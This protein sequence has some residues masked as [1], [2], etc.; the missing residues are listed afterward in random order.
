M[1]A[2]NPP[3]LPS[4]QYKWTDDDALKEERVLQY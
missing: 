3:Q 4:L 2:G 1:S